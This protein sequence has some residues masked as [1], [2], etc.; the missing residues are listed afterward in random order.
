MDGVDELIEQVT[1]DAYG[2]YEQL[3]AFWQCFED[4][5]R[6]PFPATV[7]GAH[8]DVVDVDFPGDERRGL[9]AVCRR[10]GSQHH[11]SLLDVAPCGPMSLPT[12]RLLDAYRRWSGA[13]SLPQSVDPASARW[14][15]Q[16]LSSVRMEVDDPLALHDHGMWDPAE[17]YWGEP[18]DEL[19]GLLQEVID[20][21]ARPCV[22][23][24][25]I[26]PGVTVDDWDFDPI[27]NAADLHRAG[28]HVQA[29]DVLEDL[30]AQDPRCI[31]AWGHLGLIAFDTRGPGPAR[32]F[33]ETGIAVAEASI[34]DGFTGVLAWGWVDNRPFLRCL[35]GLAL[36][37]WRQRRWDDAE[38]AFTT[39]VWLDPAGSGGALACLEPVR[40]R[41]RWTR[42]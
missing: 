4:T 40:H 5:A 16:H 27:V 33:Y 19:P 2:D 11:V 6:F 14:R 25:Q 7:V 10:D 22:E 38:A 26:I 8:V 36:C 31:D 23:M 28:Q 30:L 32:R 18:G 12:R 39:R 17:E 41:R 35:H 15:Y 34:P 9:V 24:E 13:E 37:A 1:V 20:V 3:T 42:G 29:R 21:G